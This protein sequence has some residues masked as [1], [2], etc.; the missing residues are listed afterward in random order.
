MRKSLSAFLC[1]AISLLLALVMPAARATPWLVT[2]DTSR[3]A[4]NSSTLAF[5]FIGSNGNT[6]WIRNFDAQGPVFPL[7][8]S[9]NVQ[10]AFPNT[11]SLS[12]SGSF[13]NEATLALPA[14]AGQISF[15]IDL[16]HM[17][18]A[19]GNAPD[20]LSLYFLDPWS[21]LPQFPSSDPTGAGALL[22]LDLNGSDMGGLTIFDAAEVSI[23]AH[24][25]TQNVPAPA[26]WLL[27]LPFVLLFA[28]CR[29]RAAIVAACGLLAISGLPQMARAESLN[30]LVSI[31]KSGLVLNRLSNTYDS[32]ITVTNTSTTPIGA[33]FQLTVS[34]ISA[35]GVT[36]YNS[37]G[38]DAQDNPTV[39][40]AL[41]MGVLQPGAKVTVPLKFVNRKQRAFNF[42]L[43]ASG[44]ILNSINSTQLAVRAFHYSGNPGNP[45]GAAAGAGVKLSVNGVLRALTDA[46]GQASFLVPLEA[47]S[48]SARRAPSYVGTAEL[49]LH[50]GMGN[51][52]DV[53]LSDDGEVYADATLRIDQVQHLLLPNSF[54]SM[55]LRLIGANESTIRISDL[56]TV[57]LFNSIGQSLGDLTSL[58]ALNA[59]GSIQPPDIAA[60]RS[61]IVGKSGRLTLAVTG[62]DAQ[63][64]VY[65]ATASF[66]LTR[67]AVRGTLAAPASFP[68]LQLGGIRIV[69]KI[70]NTDVVVYTVSEADGSFDFPNLPN[71]NLSIS[72]ETFQNQRYYYGTGVFSLTGAANLTIPLLSSLDDVASAQAVNKLAPPPR[73]EARV[74]GVNARRPEDL[75]A[76]QALPVLPELGRRARQAGAALAPAQVSVTAGLRNVPSTQTVKLA[77]P[78]GTAK[79]TLSYNVASAEYPYYITQQSVYNDVWGIKVF[80]G[81]QG[82]LLFD[83]TRQ[84]NTQLTQ[85]PIWL[86]DGT[87]GIIEKTFDVRAMARDGDIELTLTAFATNIGDSQLPTSVNARIEVGGSLSINSVSV[88]DDSWIALN[89]KT[90]YSVPESGRRNVFQRRNILDVTKPEGSTITNLKIELLAAGGSTVVLDEAPG[91]NVSVVDDKT[92]RTI[93]TFDTQS[94]TLNSVPPPT[95]AIQ[96]RYTLSARAADGSRPTAEK[97]DTGKHPLWRMP[98]GLPRYSLREPGGDDWTSQRSYN[99]IA[100]NRGLLRA[101]ND[102]SGEHGKDLGHASHG[103][104]SD[105][106]MYHFY[107]FPGANANSGTSNYLQLVARVKD[108]PKQNSSNPQTRAQGVAAMAQVTGWILVSRAGLDALAANADVLQI[109]YIRGGPGSAGIS[110]ADWGHRLLTT[111]R[112]TVDGVEYDLNVGSWANAK[113]HAWAN[114]HHHIHIT[115]D[116]SD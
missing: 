61:R 64:N 76:S 82:T 74:V 10:G 116:P 66:H 27:M 113:Y 89:D 39:S 81:P 43:A 72:A 51:S 57:E 115:L 42:A 22:R 93:V 6:V 100:A 67:N 15:S 7:T 107:T 71:G 88:L 53:I 33:P 92:L 91:A 73:E 97:T 48:L 69:G 106:D 68:G 11:V 30:G 70:L 17:G 19:G 37:N 49:D 21:G 104:G 2:I 94:S 79:V 111:G 103:R 18:P 63:E 46:S 84:I 34:S 45:R 54:N 24:P 90:Y 31:S 28:L 87:T 41:D 40:V 50:R 23:S 59:D 75:K 95:N 114:H 14:L 77:V 78:K 20:A 99:W 110:G 16:T 12:T 98:P 108:L 56:A 101:V 112:V 5:D 8:S 85:A 83:L 58:F 80:G 52:V 26:S 44:T 25:G 102:I 62:L 55:T 9:G 47:Q 109:G 35:A 60:L 4:G 65:R 96:Y 3:F 32:A 36:V 86:S 105:I 38:V 1:C 13:F 29:H